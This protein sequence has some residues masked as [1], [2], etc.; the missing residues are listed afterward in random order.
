MAF[1]A[2]GDQVLLGVVPRLAAE[3]LVVDFEIGQRA[4][5]LTTPAVAPQ[6]LLPEIFEG[7]RVKAHAPGFREAQ[8]HYMLSLML[9]RNACFCSSDRNRKNFVIENSNVSGFWLSRLAPA[10]KSAQIISKQ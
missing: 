5:R 3:F 1:G 8:A 10:R 7:S 6:D 9:P 4:A 2:K